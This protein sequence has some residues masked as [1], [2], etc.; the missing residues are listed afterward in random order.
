M[1]QLTFK[2][3]EEAVVET[4]IYHKSIQNYIDTLQIPDEANRKRL[5]KLLS[6]LYCTLGLL[7][8]AGE[9]AEKMKKIIR[10]KNGVISDDDL[11]L[12]KKEDGDV[13]WYTGAM[14]GELNS[15][16]AEVAQLNIDKLQ[17]RKKRG[18]IG[19]SGDNR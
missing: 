2:A 3:Y 16:F 13:V 18:V 6:T 15:D 12:L 10:D 1:S 8:E 19:G 5:H 17:D 4:G 9:I 7:G 11:Q 14:A